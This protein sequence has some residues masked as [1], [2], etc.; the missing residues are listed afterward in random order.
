[1]EAVILETEGATAIRVDAL[2]QMALLNLID[3]PD[4][5]S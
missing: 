5:R 1:M 3:E 2:S 4:D